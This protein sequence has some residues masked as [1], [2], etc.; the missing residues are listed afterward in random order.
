MSDES[1]TLEE[2]VN[3]VWTGDEDTIVVNDGDYSFDELET[4][5]VRVQYLSSDETFVGEQDLVSKSG[6]IVEVMDSAERSVEE[7]KAFD[8]HKTDSMR[9]WIN[10]NLN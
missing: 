3:E 6:V 9:E 10:E 7:R 1:R 5:A 2:A 4:S 8:S